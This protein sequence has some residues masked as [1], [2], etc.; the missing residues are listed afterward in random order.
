T[1]PQI[2]LDEALLGGIVPTVRLQRAFYS[3]GHPSWWD[4]GALA[5]YTSHFFVPAMV[6]LSLWARSRPRYL[7]YMWAFVGMTTVGYLTYALFPA[8]PPWLA[9]QRGALAPTHRLVREL[10]E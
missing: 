1:V 5:V 7:R 10:W 6:G 2:R 9:S 4:Y 8:V 3:P